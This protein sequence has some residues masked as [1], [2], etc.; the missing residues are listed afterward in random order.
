M[1]RQSAIDICEEKDETKENWWVAA[2]INSQIH[3]FRSIW[4][5]MEFL[6]EVDIFLTIN[7]RAWIFFWFV[8]SFN[9]FETK[10][11]CFGAL[12]HYSTQNKH[13]FSLQTSLE[14]LGV[15]FFV[16]TQMRNN[17]IVLG[18]FSANTSP[19]GI[20]LVWGF[21]SLPFFK[22][23]WLYQFTLFDSIFVFFCYIIC[24][25]SCASRITSKLCRTNRWNR[26]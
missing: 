19:C 11:S 22:P 8:F 10:L 2:V 16:W 25:N 4:T 23:F 26:R 9:W 7:R 1:L 15:K 3:F 21:F 24:F 18:A 20:A 17:F 5:W 12:G 13:G 6:G 14:L